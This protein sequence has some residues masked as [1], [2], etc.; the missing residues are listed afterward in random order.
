[1]N[2]GIY[3]FL[4]RVQCVKETGKIWMHLNSVELWYDLLWEMNTSNENISA[5][6]L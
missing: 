4:N 1:M 2:E 5:F 3:V 6:H